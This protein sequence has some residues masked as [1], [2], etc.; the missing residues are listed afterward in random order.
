MTEFDVIILGGGP[1]GSTLAALLAN[2]GVNVAV[3]EKA[4]F[5]RIVVGESL[6]PYSLPIWER[7]GVLP[8]LE[9]HFIRKPGARFVND[10]TLEEDWFLFNNTLRTGPEYAFN[11]TRADFD[12]LLLDHARECGAT[13]MQPVECTEVVFGDDDV[14]VRTSAGELDAQYFVDASGR[15]SFLARRQSVRENDPE[16][17][18][19]ATFAHFEG[20][21]LDEED[22]GNIFIVRF[23]DTNQGWMWMI[24]F[25]SGTASVGVVSDIDYFK[26]AGQSPEEF[27]SAQLES[28]KFM[29]PRMKYAQKFTDVMSEAEFTYS[30]GSLCGKR[31][32]KLGDAGAF[33]DPI[34]SSGILLTTIAADVAHDVLVK[35]LKDG[36]SLDGFREPIMQAVKVFR[37]F[38]NA[39]YKK[40][41]LQHMVGPH[42]R[43]LIQKG[44]TSLL[45]GDVIN[46]E[47]PLIDWLE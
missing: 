8:K 5:P 10:Q 16:H 46:A 37:T 44:I 23:A 18:K 38:I 24:P 40:D 45:A 30:G 42:K 32:L 43:P 13:I 47:N 14:T 7:S 31:W 17:R 1:G 3:I 26:Q 25:K 34:F 27:L 9:E 28:S 11:V 2:S 6:L 29:A 12:L 39:F 35:A 36:D 22:D 19:I 41:L 20:V 21:E 15:D 33:I 4:K